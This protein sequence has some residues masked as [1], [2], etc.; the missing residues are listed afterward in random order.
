MQAEVLAA[1]PPDVPLRPK[2]VHAR[3]GCWSPISIK[4]ALRSLVASGRVVPE[5]A[6]CNRRYR[7]IDSPASFPSH[8]EAVSRAP[9]AVT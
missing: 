2:E 9:A 7:R 8:E 6:D 1:M 3:V 4:H 5:G